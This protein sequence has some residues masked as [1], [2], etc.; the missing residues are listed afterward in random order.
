MPSLPEK[1][2]NHLV[3]DGIIP[4][5]D[6]PVQ[7]AALP[8]A[9]R[10]ERLF[11]FFASYPALLVL[12]FIGVYLIVIDVLHGKAEIVQINEGIERKAHGITGRDHFGGSASGQ[13]IPVS[14]RSSLSENRKTRTV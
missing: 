1:W 6:K 12:L 11:F 9:N 2:Y 14:E 7:L 8:C 10:V 5:L 13:R 4:L 3:V